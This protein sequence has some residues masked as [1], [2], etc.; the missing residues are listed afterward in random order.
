M[1]PLVDANNKSGDVFF[2]LLYADVDF[3]FLYKKTKKKRNNI[4]IISRKK[5]QKNYS[6]L[7]CQ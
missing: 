5:E 3:L 6:I 1:M 2:Y 4:L 7:Y